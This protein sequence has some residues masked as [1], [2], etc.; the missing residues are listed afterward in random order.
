MAFT[1]GKSGNPDGRPRG[2]ENKVTADMRNLIADIVDENVDG[3]RS[4][5]ES[6]RMKNPAKY[7][8]LVI[9]LAAM[10]TPAAK[11]EERGFTSPILVDFSHV[12][13]QTK[14][15]ILRIGQQ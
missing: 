14:D 4:A 1:A 12:S 7:A 8:E 9:K 5:L 15:S 2:T 10:I 13:Q 3:L 6:I 11:P